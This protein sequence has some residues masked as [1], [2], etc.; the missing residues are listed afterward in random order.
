MKPFS[1]I[2]KPLCVDFRVSITVVR[3]WIFRPILTG[4]QG[5]IVPLPG[6]LGLEV[7]TGGERL[8]CF[9]DLYKKVRLSDW[10]KGLFTRRT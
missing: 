2:I 6:E 3:D 7:T 1:E 10:M 9:D 4:S 8:T 5:V